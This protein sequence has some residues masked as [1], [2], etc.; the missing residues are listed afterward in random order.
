MSRASSILLL[1]VCLLQPNRISV[2]LA[3]MS[4]RRPYQDHPSKSLNIEV[5]DLTC[6]APVTIRV[7]LC[8]PGWGL[9][10]RWGFHHAGQTSL[11]LL[12]SGNPPALASQSAESPCVA[13][14]GVQ[15][16]DHLSSLQPLLPVSASRVAGT[17]GVHHHARLI[18]VYLVEMGFHFIGQV[19]LYLLTFSW[20]YR[21]APPCLSNVCGFGRD[22]FHSVSQASLEHL[23]SD[24]LPTS[25]SKLLGLQT[26]ALTPGHIFGLYALEA[27]RSQ[28]KVLVAFV[29]GGGFFLVA[30]NVFS[31][32]PHMLEGAEELPLGFFYKS[33]NPTDLIT[34]QSPHPP[35]LTRFKYDMT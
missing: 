3:L 32:G 22:R 8:P 26:R 21:C 19:G 4:T 35:I 5:L 6:K 15:G 23:T 17:T 24:Y 18:F 14:A 30:V 16:C 13:Q 12:T 28:S 27:R 2:C 25:A 20:E 34:S 31:L 11:E 29:S 10:R 7:L 9:M 1:C 33:S